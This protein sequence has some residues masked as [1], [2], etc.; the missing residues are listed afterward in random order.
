MRKSLLQIF[1]GLNLNPLFPNVILDKHILH[2][3]PKIL[4]S[5]FQGLIS[6]PLFSST[7]SD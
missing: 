4:S 5:I 1:Q 7:V 6:D 3:M 2:L